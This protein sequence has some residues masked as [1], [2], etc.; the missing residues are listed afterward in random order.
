MYRRAHIPGFRFVAC[1]A[2]VFALGACGKDGEP[3]PAD[4]RGTAEGRAGT[5]EREAQSTG[6]GAASE[7]CGKGG[8]QCPGRLEC[9]TWRDGSQ[10]CGP[11]AIE[12]AV[13]IT[14]VTLGGRCVFDDPS[15]ALPGASIASLQLIGTDG[16]VK[17]SGRMVWDAPGFEV[18][19]ERGNPPD[20]GDSAG[21][22]CSNYYNIGCDGQ[23]VF[24]I[25]GEDGEV[26]DLRE[27]DTVIVHLRG[28]ETCGEQVAD[29][30]QSDICTDP[31]AAADG[32]LESCTSRVRMV[33]A[34]SDLYGP[35][36]VGGTIQHIA[37]KR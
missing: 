20:G 3:E 2:L 21:D 25:V 34:R 13:L 32:N 27:G 5:A 33:S 11:A 22:A 15:D 10:A 29:E 6:A 26:Q 14:D 37:E 24:E 7:A 18:A 4:E 1:L 30:V 16:K 12:A 19:A 36:R 17:G 31:D 8:S 9:L 28:Q 35:D 23:A